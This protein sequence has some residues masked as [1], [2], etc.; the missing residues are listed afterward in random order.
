MHFIGN[1]ISFIFVCEKKHK[2]IFFTYNLTSIN[3]KRPFYC[4]FLSK[5]NLFRLSVHQKNFHFFR[6]I[7]FICLSLSHFSFLLKKKSQLL[8]IV[9]SML[10]HTFLSMNFS[11]FASTKSTNLSLDQCY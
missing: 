5:L 6:D 9:V 3:E 2:I 7:L 4:T 8:H 10:F 11:I 1:H